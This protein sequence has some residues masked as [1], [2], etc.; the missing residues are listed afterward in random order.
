M[1]KSASINKYAVV[2][3]TATEEIEAV[4][5]SWLRSNENSTVCSWPPY[6]SMSRLTRAISSYEACT[7]EW[8]TYDARLVR[9]CGEYLSLI[10]I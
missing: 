6:K 2:K 7:D 5:L 8:D 3:F 1:K 9:H 10:H 4:P